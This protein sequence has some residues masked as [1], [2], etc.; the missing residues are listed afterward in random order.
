MST[1]QCL[2]LAANIIEQASKNDLDTL[3]QAIK[4][5]KY[6]LYKIWRQMA[7]SLLPN[8]LTIHMDAYQCINYVFSHKSVLWFVNDTNPVVG[9]DVCVQYGLT[10]EVH[11]KIARA[12][13]TT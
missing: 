2:A 11:Q 5:R 1:L 4:T 8:L 9:G 13:T 7:Y 3:E 10:L 6:R 12:Q